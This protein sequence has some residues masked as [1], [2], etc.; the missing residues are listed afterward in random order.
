M[1]FGTA[2]CL[3][4]TARDTLTGYRDTFDDDRELLNRFLRA[5]LQEGVIV[6]PDGRLYVSTAHGEDDA[7]E[8]LERLG[9]AL[10]VCAEQ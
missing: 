2:F 3:H 4:F 9:R 1:G 7:D 8:T 10:A 6:V 5:A